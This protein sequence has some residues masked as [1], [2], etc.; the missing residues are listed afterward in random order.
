MGVWALT[1]RRRSRR[2]EVVWPAALRCSF[3]NLDETVGVTVTQISATGARL[4]IERLQVGPYNIAQRN[5]LS[6]LALA[7]ALPAGT[8]EVPV[9]KVRWYDTDNETR[10]F[11]MGVAFA[12]MKGE[13]QLVLD[14]VLD[15]L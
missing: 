8:F 1:E 3:P 12:E 7:A 15:S 2:F 9:I 4:L 5:E 11:R 10:F 6:T 14:R 13:S